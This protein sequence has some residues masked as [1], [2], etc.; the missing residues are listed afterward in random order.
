MNK[1][2]IYLF[3]PLCG[4]CYGATATISKLH[5]NP[6]VNVELLPTGLFADER[7]KLMTDEFAAYAC[8]LS[9]PLWVQNTGC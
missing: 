5:E 7:A 6:D 3:D 2:L 9:S 8:L 1:T 4:W